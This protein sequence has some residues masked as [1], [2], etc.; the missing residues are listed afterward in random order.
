MTEFA[1]SL[2]LSELADRAYALYE[3]FRPEVPPGKK[4]WGAAGPLDLTRI[5]A[6]AR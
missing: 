1:R 2:P 4:G 3:A 5:R 6:M